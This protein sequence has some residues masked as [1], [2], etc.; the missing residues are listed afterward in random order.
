[1]GTHAGKSVFVAGIAALW[2]LALISGCSGPKTLPK[3]WPVPELTLPER[4]KIIEAYKRP[5]PPGS[6]IAAVNYT[7]V[8]QCSMRPQQVIDDVEGKLRPLR[9]M[10]AASRLEPSKDAR[11]Y[12]ALDKR[13]QV[14][15]NTK[16]PRP[17]F[18]KYM[19]IIT[20]NAQVTDVSHDA[21]PF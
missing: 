7:V 4:S 20:V 18:G 3:D 10:R 16:P 17:T 9:Y 12:L 19:L 6:L 11:L 1:M 8:F 21:T 5:N 15:L 14:L 13:T 2:G